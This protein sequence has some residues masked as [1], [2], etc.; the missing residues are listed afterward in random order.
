[1]ILDVIVAPENS[2]IQLDE[3]LEQDARDGQAF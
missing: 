2:G 1:M 3:A